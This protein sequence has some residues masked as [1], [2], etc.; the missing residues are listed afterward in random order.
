[1]AGS[2]LSR[3]HPLT[4]AVRSAKV[5]GQGIAAFVAFAF[6]G[7]LS[8]RGFEFAA[9]AALIL[10]GTVITAA[11]S[12]L[13]WL[14]FRYGISGN[15]LLIDEGWLVKKRR[16]IPLA[17][18]QGVDIR[19]SV[20]SRVLG[21]AD[22]LVQTAGGGDSGAEARIGSIPLGDAEAL[23]ARLIGRQAH[24]SA[25]ASD[26]TADDLGTS[27]EQR[28]DGADGATMMIG[29]DPLGRM[30]DLRGAFG[31]AAP[32]EQAQVF[33]LKISLGRLVAAGLTSNG[34][35]IAVAATLGLAGQFYEIV[36]AGQL[37]E[38]VSALAVLAI[39][40]L[41]A[42]AVAAFLVVGGV[43][44]AITISRDYGFTVRRTGDRLETEA[45]LFERRMTSVP[46]RRIQ[47]VVV[48]SNPLRR[49]LKLAS[50]TV[51]TAGFGANEDQEAQG[52]SSALV[53]LAK[54]SEIRLLLHSLLWEAESFATVRP[55]PTRALRFYVFV[56]TVGAIVATLL[57]I[58][59]PW[60]LLKG[61]PGF[62]ALV[63]TAPLIVAVAVLVV[64]STVGGL[65]ALAWRAAGWGVDD[66]SLVIRWGSLGIHRSRVG[67]SRIQSM[68]IRQNP[69]QRR[70]ALATLDVA[71][72]SGSSQKLFSV[73]NIDVTDAARIEAWYSPDRP[74]AEPRLTS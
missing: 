46:V 3:T 5:L 49:L 43:A 59:I 15:D 9:I 17:R 68:S 56:P 54:S 63:A 28:L 35:L 14:F 19:A 73:R 44:V 71:S 69:F 6:F 48:E 25:N 26:A 31:G 61:E 2:E 22:V 74:A 53:P 21:L 72:V 60:W 32:A 65:R 42:L 34:P 10:L 45:G 18:V 4:V 39:P 20:L 38:A 24:V 47:S 40:A 52:S 51:N 36:D 50:V 55:L 64:A 57:A 30:S 16:S 67:R 70:A 8:G 7:A 41:I 62:D 11:Y 58:G 27:S 13:N 23:R 66:D 1:M 29:P 12:W 33:E 37:G